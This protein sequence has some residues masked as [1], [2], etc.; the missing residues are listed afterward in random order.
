MAFDVGIGQNSALRY[1]SP[2]FL[3]YKV[4]LHADYMLF[5]TAPNAWTHTV[6]KPSIMAMPILC[7]G[8]YLAR[9]TYLAEPLLAKPVR[10][11][12]PSGCWQTHPGS[13]TTCLQGVP[14]GGA[15]SALMPVDKASRRRD[16]RKIAILLL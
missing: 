3:W 4:P 6:M 2:G 8:Y 12:L 16:V 11:I 15:G 5:L 1:S 7:W 10:S 9:Q 14:V 13:P